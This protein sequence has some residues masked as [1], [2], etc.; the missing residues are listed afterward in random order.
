MTNIFIKITSD[1]GLYVSQVDPNKIQLVTPN[2]VNKL[3]VK[4]ENVRH[5]IQ[6]K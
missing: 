3:M 6:T 5:K 2:T 4:Y 1:L